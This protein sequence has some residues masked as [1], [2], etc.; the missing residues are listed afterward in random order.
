MLISS[1][2]LVLSAISL[3]TSFAATCYRRGGEEISSE[4]QPCFPEKKHSACCSLSKGSGAPG[5]ICT[6]DGLC[7]AQI[8]PWTGH[9]YLNGCT[10]R[11]WNSPDCPSICSGTTPTAGIHILPCPHLG[12]N[13]WCCSENGDNC[14]DNAFDLKLGRLVFSTSISSSLPTS[15]SS[16]SSPPTNSPTISSDNSPQQSSSPTSNTVGP[17]CPPNS[18]LNGQCQANSKAVTVGAGLGAA[19]GACLLASAVGFWFQR[20]RYNKSLQEL[21]KLQENSFPSTLPHVNMNP[22]EL[23]SNPK[24]V[25]FEMGNDHQN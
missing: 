13:R 24:P 19:L 23:P 9:L 1:T 15:S 17:T 6:S 20:R 14:C 10:D 25:L 8:A 11:T 18:S 7:M 21:R 5:D 2:F 16:S 12:L 4:Q 3:H 22:R